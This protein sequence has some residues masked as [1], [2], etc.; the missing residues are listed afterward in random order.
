MRAVVVDVEGTTT[1]VSFVHEVLFPY[2]R[3]RLP[4]L[5]RERAGEPEVAAALAEVARVAPGRDALD[6][7]V[8]WMD[9]D[10]KAGPLKAL[11][12]VLWRGGY[13]EG[14]LRGRVYP[15]VAPALRAWRAAG[16]SLWVYSS[17]SVEAQRLIFGHSDAGDLAGLFSGFFDTGVGGK[18]EAGSYAAIVEAVGVEAGEVLFLSDVAEELDAAE[19]AGVRACQVVRGEDGTVASGRHAA[20][21]DFAEVGAA[22][23]L[24]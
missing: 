9:G 20:A 12:G 22:F 4:A 7:L 21:A 5:V 10:V 16:V 14:V 15:D 18:R 8:G 13:A 3:A 19:A 11:Q 17:G 6:V 23:G 1:P 2:A 24:G